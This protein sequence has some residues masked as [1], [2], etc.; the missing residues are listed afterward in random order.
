[1]I[2]VIGG[3]GYIGSHL[4]KELVK[5]NEVV[6]LDKAEAVDDYQLD[7]KKAE[8]TRCHS[9]FAFASCMVDNSLLTIDLSEALTVATKQ[10]ISSVGLKASNVDIGGPIW[11]VQNLIQGATTSIGTT[12][13]GRNWLRYHRVKVSP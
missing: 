2:L 13:T 6:V 10:L 8:V 11:V 4:V 7:P 3:A 5:T 1:M 9:P 12:M